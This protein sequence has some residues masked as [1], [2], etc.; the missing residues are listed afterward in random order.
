MLSG[1]QD[2]TGGANQ[3]E[4]R[5]ENHHEEDAGSCTHGANGKG[6]V[7]HAKSPADGVVPEFPLDAQVWPLLL[8][9]DGDPA[10]IEVR[11]TQMLF[12]EGKQP[13]IRRKILQRFWRDT[14]G[15]VG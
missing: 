9:G 10:G 3:H 1:W 14:V 2:R 7:G 13:N 8:A 11:Q 12:A 4:Q 6:L 5:N 15:R